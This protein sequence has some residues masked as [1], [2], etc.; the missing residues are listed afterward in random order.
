[1]RTRP[2]ESL[3]VVPLL[4]LLAAGVSCGPYGAG[5]TRANL[6]PSAPPPRHEELRP[7]VIHP[8]FKPGQPPRFLEDAARAALNTPEIDAAIEQAEH[9]FHNGEKFFQQGHLDN[10]RAAFDRAIDILLDAPV[11]AHD[12][13]RAEEKGLEVAAA[14]CSFDLDGA[15]G[16]PGFDASP[17]D[18]VLRATFPV[19][20]N[21][22]LNVTEELKLP[23][24]E[25]PLEVN[26]E[27]MKYI[28]YFSSARGRKTLVNGLRRMGR[29]QPMIQRI[30]DEEG[31][32]QELIH[33][34]QA[35]S[36]FLPRAISR[37]RATGMWQFMR[38]RGRE[39]GLE[40]TTQYDDRLD[41]E[42]A[43]RAAAR[44]LRD[45]YEQLG[46]WYL[47][48]AAY[49]SGPGR[50]D[51]AVRR[52]G[53][54]DFWEFRRRRA[55]PRETLNYVPI[56]LATIILVNNP[57]E[58]ALQDIVPDPPLT[59]NTI[60]VAAD[61]HL[62]LIADILGRS[63]AEMRELNPAILKDIAPAGYQVHV[64]KG[65]ANFVMTSLDTVPAD[66]RASWRVH[67]VGF[68]ET[69]AEIAQLY[70]TTAESLAEAN[71]GSLDL[72]EAGDLVL[73]P[74]SYTPPRR[75]S[76]APSRRSTSSRSSRRSSS[77]KR[78][79]SRT[80]GA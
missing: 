14:I 67:R 39:Y 59:Y 8:E 79:S 1:M 56:I 9:S 36:G 17:L 75:I 11:A 72:P 76:N 27:V 33:L 77:T 70:K 10:A 80:P 42:K 43:T 68:G 7:P 44:H 53:Y 57:E 2:T 19:D 15:G 54:A 49:N 71:G 21:I 45:L 24:S 30:L 31:V 65:T 38:Y 78:R 63:L 25:L 69:F 18:E 3:R 61:T 64:P 46:D 29:Y 48:I 26:G 4:A 55:L 28:K 6:L 60:Q 58:Y 5:K 12:R 13:F 62:G 37:K 16:Q 20:P 74:V 35:E 47:A 32:P 73:V 23:V 40:I 41:P 34:A 22:E 52:T 66:R 50:I 51:Q